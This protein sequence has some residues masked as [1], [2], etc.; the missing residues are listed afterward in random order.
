MFTLHCD[1]LASLYSHLTPSVPVT[2]ARIKWLPEMNGWYSYF[3]SFLKILFPIYLDTLVITINRIRKIFFFL[4]IAQ[5]S[6]GLLKAT[7]ACSGLWSFTISTTL[8]F[9]M[10]SVEVSRFYPAVSH[11]SSAHTPS[12]HTPHTHTP[13]CFRTFMNSVA[14]LIIKRPSCFCFVVVVQLKQKWQQQQ[15]Q[16]WA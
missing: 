11:C 13:L 2:L 7:V 3:S 15:K 6:R 16:P 12:A 9:F 10:N 8:Q 14:W 1:E 4:P 5:D